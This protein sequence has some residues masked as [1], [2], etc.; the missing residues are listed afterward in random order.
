MVYIPVIFVPARLLS[1]EMIPGSQRNE[2]ATGPDGA[3]NRKTFS[4]R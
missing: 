1:K 4:G 2:Y 3:T